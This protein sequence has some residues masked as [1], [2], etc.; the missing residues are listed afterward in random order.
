MFILLRLVILLPA[1][2][3]LVQINGTSTSTTTTT[4][5]PPDTGPEVQQTGGIL[6]WNPTTS[7][8]PIETGGPE[9]HQT[10]GMVVVDNC[11]HTSTVGVDYPTETSHGN[12]LEPG[13]DVV[14]GLGFG[15]LAFILSLFG[16]V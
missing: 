5:P 14:A 1:A 7:C 10:A 2:S 6:D 3:A 11:G 9:V 13:T 12:A 4:K 8:D 16:W 15:A